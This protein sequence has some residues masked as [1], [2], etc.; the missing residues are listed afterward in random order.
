MRCFAA[1]DIGAGP[2][3]LHAQLLGRCAACS[4]TPP[5]DDELPRQSDTELLARR[6]IAFAL[7]GI[8]RCS[9]RLDRFIVGLELLQPPARLD[10]DVGARAD[11]RAG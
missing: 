4:D 7:G 1:Q 3:H 6:F 8:E 2:A 5:V 9:A 11:C 10:E